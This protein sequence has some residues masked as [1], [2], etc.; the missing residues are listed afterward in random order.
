MKVE[1]LVHESIKVKLD[2]SSIFQQKLI[3][4]LSLSQKDSLEFFDNA[5]V[6]KNNRYEVK[7][8]LSILAVITA[9][10]KT[11]SKL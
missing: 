8:P 5:T 6:F 10:V 4:D 3:N 7:L 9:H 1:S 11:G 2:L